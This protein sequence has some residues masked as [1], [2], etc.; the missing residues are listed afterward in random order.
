MGI[1]MEKY[2][3]ITI[4][5]ICLFLFSNGTIHLIIYNRMMT[6]HGFVTSIHFPDG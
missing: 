2:V 3:Q 1:L 6:L 5:K 4:I